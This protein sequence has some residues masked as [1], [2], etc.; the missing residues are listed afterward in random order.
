MSEAEGGG[1]G[2]TPATMPLGD[3]DGDVGAAAQAMSA[4]GAVGM[5]PRLSRLTV[6]IDYQ[7]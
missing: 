5:A 7:D 4:G 1:D 2:A 6:K 3:G